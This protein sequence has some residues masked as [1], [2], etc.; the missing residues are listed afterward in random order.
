M[1]AYFVKRRAVPGLL[2]T[3]FLF[4]FS[5]IAGAWTPGI[6]QALKN[7][8]V[9]GAVLAIGN[10]KCNP[11][12]KKGWAVLLTN[13]DI[14]NLMRL[15][16]DIPKAVYQSIQGQYATIT[17]EIAHAVAKKNGLDM[18]VQISTNKTYSPGTDTDLVL[19]GD[20]T[21]KTPE[22]IKK[23]QNEFNEKFGKAI[24]ELDPNSP[25]RK[26]VFTKKNDVDFMV[27]PKGVNKETFKAIAEVNNDAY[28]DPQAAEFE[29]KIR[30]NEIPT[31]AET[32]A[33]QDEMKEFVT[34]KKA[35]IG[36]LNEALNSPDLSDFRKKKLKAEHKL[37]MMQQSKYLLRSHDAVDVAKKITNPEYDPAND[38]NRK[39][40]REELVAAAARDPGD[41]DIH[42]TKKVSESADQIIDGNG[43][44]QAAQAKGFC[45]SYPNKCTRGVTDILHQ[46][47]KS[48]AYNVIDNKV[49]L[50]AGQATK[51]LLQP[52]KKLLNSPVAKGVGKSF[53]FYGKLLDA[54]DLCDTLA[55]E[56]D[57]ALDEE[58]PGGSELATWATV[59]LNTLIEFSGVPVLAQAA[60]AATAKAERRV[61]RLTQDSG[62]SAEKVDELKAQFI[63]EELSNTISTMAVE[64]LPALL[65]FPSKTGTWLGDITTT[66]QAEANENHI[67]MTRKLEWYRPRQAKIEEFLDIQS[68]LVSHGPDEVL[69][70]RKDVLSNFFT[71][72]NDRA[73]KRGSDE[74]AQTTRWLEKINEANE[75]L[76]KRQEVPSKQENETA[77]QRKAASGAGGADQNQSWDSATEPE[78]AVASG[79]GGTGQSGLVKESQ[80]A[81][82]WQVVAD[83][84]REVSETIAK[85]KQEQESTTDQPNQVIT[86]G[87]SN[88]NTV[89]TTSTNVEDTWRNSC[90]KLKKKM[91]FHQSALG[92]QKQN[93]SNEE[94]EWKKQA[95]E[96][97]RVER[98][99]VEKAKI[100]LKSYTQK[101]LVSF[102]HSQKRIDGMTEGTVKNNA[103]KEFNA[104]LR[105]ARSEHK[106]RQAKVKNRMT[107]Y[108]NEWAIPWDKFKKA[109]KSMSGQSCGEVVVFNKSSWAAG[110]VA[111]PKTS[112]TQACRQIEAMVSKERQVAG[113]ARS[114]GCLDQNSR[115]HSALIDTDDAFTDDSGS[116]HT[117]RCA[118][119]VREGSTTVERK[120][121]NT[122]IT[123][124]RCNKTGVEHAIQFTF[125][126]TNTA[127][128]IGGVS[129]WGIGTDGNRNAWKALCGC[130]SPG[131]SAAETAD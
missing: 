23:I 75:D 104:Q 96:A 131:N 49:S 76:V 36:K 9:D 108:N 97:I 119:Y 54:K 47:G 62:L 33:Y 39:Q 73:C 82:A 89:Q 52:G 42:K 40:K 100:S 93:F 130:S 3:C 88:P 103:M 121:G 5:G 28:K 22:N 26:E 12:C 107:S 16:D 48:N 37:K 87:G 72:M 129:S 64:I 109:R 13:N 71:E 63:F 85:L 116:G 91:E 114:L 21:K 84:A 79:T 120:V 6:N 117:E 70:E 34:K 45:R 115:W 60:G 20:P 43:R 66:G 38:V 35:E 44:E 25:A 1:R 68:H 83:K 86:G 101:T 18:S 102:E 55:A 56:T 125:K 8:K 128:H 67:E 123:V 24:G 32:L 14:V 69:E 30:A 94:Q 98:S 77:E 65:N 58:A 80:Q 122:Y 50:N 41:N 11:E 15:E 92:R 81:E 4:F 29:R 99:K 27:D 127:G 113:E 110:V 126:V 19:T 105:S 51:R 124:I 59:S 53:Q 78:Q 10:P 2:V 17:Q 106:K 61:E 95:F 7:V 46:R 111:Y 112:Q 57:K 74:C 90:V 31:M 118:G